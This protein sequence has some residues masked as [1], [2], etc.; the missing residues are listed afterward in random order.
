MAKPIVSY[1]DA[2]AK[3]LKRYYTGKPC[4]HGHLAERFVS[5]CRCMDCTYAQTAEWLAGNKELAG[6]LQKKWRDENPQYSREWARNNPDSIRAAKQKWYASKPERAIQIAVD[7][8]KRNPEK[9]RASIRN[10]Q[11]R[12]RQAEGSHTAGE[13]TAMLERQKW[14]CV[15]CGVSIKEKRHIDHIIPLILGGT[16]YIS[17]LQGLCPRCNQSKNGKH[18]DVWAR[19]RGLLI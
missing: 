11:A 1:K 10:R 9:R 15:A 19:E 7:W 3:G 4:K 14:K 16:N 17:N 13:I 6:Q 12:K 8:Q 5:S 18:P 2:K